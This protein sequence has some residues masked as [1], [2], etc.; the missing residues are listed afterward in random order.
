MNTQIQE[1]FAQLKQF[2]NE[3]T[4]QFTCFAERFCIVN[5]ST[6]PSQQVQTFFSQLHALSENL[7]QFAGTLAI[8]SVRPQVLPEMG[9]Q[10]SLSDF[11]PQGAKDQFFQVKATEARAAEAKAEA[12]AEVK[13]AE[14]KIAEL[15]AKLAIA[16]DADAKIA[17][18]EAKITAAKDVEAKIAELEAKIAAGKEADEKIAELDAKLVAAKEV[19][20]KIAEFGARFMSADT[21]TPK[22]PIPAI[23]RQT[24]VPAKKADE[25]AWKAPEASIAV[26]QKV[27]T[28]VMS[29]V[30]ASIQKDNFIKV[31]NKK[32][33]LEVLKDI[34]KRYPNNDATSRAKITKALDDLY[35]EHFDLFRTFNG[36]IAK[37][38]FDRGTLHLHYTHD[39]IW[40]TDCEFFEC[41]QAPAYVKILFFT[42]GQDRGDPFIITSKT[43]DTVYDY[44]VG[45]NGA[46][47]FREYEKDECDC[48]DAAD[49]TCEFQYVPAVV[50]GRFQAYYLHN[51]NRRVRPEDVQQELANRR[52]HRN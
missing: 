34:A 23:Q 49:C 31:G 45:D 16:K 15:D 33:L 46:L 51:L 14:A 4:A 22:K 8:M 18:L 9:F 21:N 30:A 1:V 20:D 35:T 24:P 2:T 10:G 39:L 25:P 40:R 12:E 26:V 27:P 19:E 32:N 17:E 41:K 13:K 5:P 38:L 11:L 6:P 29:T 42:V 28:Q 52:A 43:N 50:N 7:T 3:T 48:S 47:Y 36:K 44:Y 37:A